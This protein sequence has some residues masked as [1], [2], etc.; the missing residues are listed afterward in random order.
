MGSWLVWWQEFKA[1]AGFHPSNEGF[2]KAIR[3]DDLEA[4]LKKSLLA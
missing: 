2:C 3:E 4:G 1:T